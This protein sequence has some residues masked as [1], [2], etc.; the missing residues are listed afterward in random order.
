MK[1]KRFDEVSS[2]GNVPA[3][4]ERILE[5][6]EKER[7]FEKS[8]EARSGAGDFVFYEG[9]PTA[10]GLPG[11]HH[12]MARLC[13]DVV[14]RYKTMR[15]FRVV[16]KGG[17]DT[18]GLPV[19]IEVENKLGLA[20]KEQI[21]AIGIG[22]FNA[23]C[24]ESVFTYEKEWKRFTQRIGYW[25]DMENPYITCAN[26]YIESVWWMLKEFWKNGL[27]YE[28]HKIVP[29]CP[30]CGTSLSSHEV[31]QGYK[32]V[33]DPSIFVRF[34]AAGG[35]ESFLVWTTTPW[36]L[37]SNAALAVGADF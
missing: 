21:E 33:S 23:R 1:Q 34:K 31:S 25:L 16:R 27:L 12:V 15:G 32:D 29:Y 11:V 19:E 7:T 4:E 30:R 17:W 8:V 6:W 14:C 20:S 35:G 28:G 18:H 2:P 26:D 22:E 24:R 36:T 37:I 3:A 5:F 10:N 9:P 13:K